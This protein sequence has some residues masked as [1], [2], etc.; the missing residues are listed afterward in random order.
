MELPKFGEEYSLHI[1]TEV[2]HQVN[3]AIFSITP[4]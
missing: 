2:E 4:L 1:M 3:H